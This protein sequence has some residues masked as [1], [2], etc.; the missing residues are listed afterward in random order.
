MRVYEETFLLMKSFR[1]LGFIL[2]VGAAGSIS[3]PLSAAENE[4]AILAVLKPV[5]D[6]ALRGDFAA[7]IQAMPDG[8]AGPL[9]PGKLLTCS[10]GASRCLRGS[11]ATSF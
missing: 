3:H 1:L 7:G 4:D 10:A 11:T 5:A 9:V 8:R 6:A 2:A